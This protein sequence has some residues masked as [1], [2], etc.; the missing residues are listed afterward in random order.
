[1]SNSNI[2]FDTTNESK[3]PIFLEEC[4]TPI[5][6]KLFRGTINKYHSYVK[7]KDSPTRNI[8]WLVYESESGNQIGAIGLSSA[9]IAV[10]VRDNY[11]G[12]DNKTKMANLCHLANNSRFC[13]IKIRTTIKNSASLTLKQLR[14][15]GSKRWKEKYDDDLLLLETFVLPKRDNDFNGFE[16]RRGSCYLSDNW[17]NIGETQGNHIRKTPLGLWTRE[18]G[19]RGRLAREDPE[20]CLKLHAGYLGKCNSSGYKITKVSKKMMFICPLIWNWKDRLLKI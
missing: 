15:Q 12:W 4:K 7:Y 8:R 1:M 16:I 18:K 5:Q 17:I 3:I 13:L 2:F 20:K 11:I 10:S 19:E 14:L 9:T 6:N